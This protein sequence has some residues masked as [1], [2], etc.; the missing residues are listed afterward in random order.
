VRVEAQD[1]S[2][3]E[4]LVPLAIGKV[5]RWFSE[6]QMREKFMDCTQR[7]LP[8]ARAA[9]LFTLLRGLPKLPSVAALDAAL[10]CD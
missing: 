7:C 5:G 10:I 9:E 3:R 4:E 1:G 8:P 2:S 6:E